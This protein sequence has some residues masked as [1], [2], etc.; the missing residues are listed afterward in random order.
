MLVSINQSGP[1]KMFLSFAQSMTKDLVDPYNLFLVNFHVR[2]NEKKEA[3]VFSPLERLPCFSQ[4]CVFNKL[5][6]PENAFLFSRVIV[7]IA[8]GPLKLSLEV[9]H[10]RYRE[11]K[12]AKDICHRENSFYKK[13]ICFYRHH[14]SQRN[15]FILFK[16]FVRIPSEPYKVRNA[17]MFVTLDDTRKKGQKHF[18]SWKQFF[19][20]MFFSIGLLGPRKMILSFAQK[21]STYLVYA[22]NMFR[23]FFMFDKTKEFQPKS[24]LRWKGCIFFETVF[25][26][27]PL[28]S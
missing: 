27:Q 7:S 14:R 20:E 22:Y 2:W 10:N 8:C 25:F 23:A 3:K 26:Q 19:F 1:K 11:Q 16:N 5:L 6:F 24:I 28:R 15:D 4:L 17:P 9:F 12:W 18:S 13:N 21:R